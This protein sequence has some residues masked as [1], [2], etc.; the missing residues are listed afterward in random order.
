MNGKLNISLVTRIIFA[1]GILLFLNS[2]VLAQNS[3]ENGLF[4]AK[5]ALKNRIEIDLSEEQIASIQEIYTSHIAE[6]EIMRFDLD[7]QLVELDKIMKSEKVDE[8]KATAQ[9]QKVLRLEEQLKRV[10]LLMLIRIKNTLSSNQQAQLKELRTENDVDGFLMKAPI[11]KNQSAIFQLADIQGN[12]SEPL[13]II[14]TKS[15]EREVSLAYVQTLNMSDILSIS[16]IKDAVATEK[17]GPKGK[18]GVV[19]LE[20]K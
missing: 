16:I 14:K 6:F 4:S 18:N 9:L 2:G 13:F 12:G 5:L 3:F 20:L 17:Y 10:R 19:F 8:N 1:V 15:G 11:N 7:A